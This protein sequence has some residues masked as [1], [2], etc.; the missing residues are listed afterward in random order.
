M[1]F[2][3]CFC[4]CVWHMGEEKENIT[5]TVYRGRFSFSPWWCAVL[6]FVSFFLGVCAREDAVRFSPPLLTAACVCVYCIMCVLYMGWVG[7]SWSWCW[8]GSY[9]CDYCCDFFVSLYMNI[10]CYYYY[11]LLPSHLWLVYFIIIYYCLY[12]YGIFVK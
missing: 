9:C 2:S 1:F 12:S 10:C 11:L 4:M 8:W 7:G 3:S 5:Y 6:G